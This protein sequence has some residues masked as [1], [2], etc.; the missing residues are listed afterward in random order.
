MKKLI[1][2]SVVIL[3]TN[4]LCIAQNAQKNIAGDYIKS[5]ECLGVELDGSQT[6]KSW[7]MG[8]RKIDAIE[9]AKKNAVRDVL[10]KG[11]RDGQQECNQIPIIN[12]PNTIN[13]NEDYF[14][15]FF[16]DNG[17]YKEFV[18]MKDTPFKLFPNDKKKASKGFQYGVIVRVLR[19]ELKNKMIVDNILVP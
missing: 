8:T 1:L 5:S 2:I 13:K 18:S 12:S 17:P 16:A 6:I 19:T 15:K 9:Q 3:L 11:I 7:G 10:F 4:N 14:Y